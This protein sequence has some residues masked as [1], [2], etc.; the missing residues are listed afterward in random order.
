MTIENKGE[1]DFSFN[2]YTVSITG[3][4]PLTQKLYAQLTNPLYW[5]SILPHNKAT[6]EVVFAV[7]KSIQVFTLTFRNHTG[8]YYFTQEIGNIPIV[9]DYSASLFQ[10][11]LLE[12]QNFSYVVENLDTPMKAAEYTKEKFGFH[13]RGTCIGQT[14]TAF[15]IE[16]KGDCLSYANFFSYVLS[17]HGYDVKKVSFKYHD[18]GVRLG[19]VV[20]LFTD[21]DG[22]LK[23]ATTPDLRV[24]R[25]VSSVDD[26]IVQ[27]KKR[28]NIVQLDIKNGI[29]NIMIIPVEDTS[30]CHG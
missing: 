6:G 17:Q 25:N 18:Q 5:G 30:S 23:Y 14:P 10:P 22:Q 26:L 9:K 27:E 1:K 4:G 21:R 19:H 13:D 16:G 20:T 7:N 8:K 11:G 24:L 3:G 2:E 12:S 15:F 29:E 28:L